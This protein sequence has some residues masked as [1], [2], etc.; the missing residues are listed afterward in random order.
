LIISSKENY[1]NIVVMSSNFVNQAC[2]QETSLPEKDLLPCVETSCRPSRLFQP[3]S[4]AAL[5]TGIPEPGK[6]NQ[7]RLSSGGLSSV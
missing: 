3:F 4:V 7:K 6:K 1:T 5:K 2:R